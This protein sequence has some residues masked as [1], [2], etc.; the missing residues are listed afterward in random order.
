MALKG[1]KSQ[2]VRVEK[3]PRTITENRASWLSRVKGGK[4]YS[5]ENWKDSR[6][7]PNGGELHSF[8]ES[9]RFKGYQKEENFVAFQSRKDSSRCQKYENFTATDNG[10]NP[11]ATKRRKVS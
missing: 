9:K 7:I 10:K 2:F 5:Y 3:F 1:R 11:K 8:W 6:W 4:N